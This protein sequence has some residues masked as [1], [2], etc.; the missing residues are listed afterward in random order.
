MQQSLPAYCLLLSTNLLHRT[1]DSLIRDLPD[2]Y[3]VT[4]ILSLVRII[5]VPGMYQH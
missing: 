5:E 4:V 1:F 3:S 2:E